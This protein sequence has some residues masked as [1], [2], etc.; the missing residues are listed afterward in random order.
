MQLQLFR[1]LPLRSTFAPVVWILCGFL[2]FAAFSVGF[3]L[4]SDYRIQ[5]NRVNIMWAALEPALRR[6]AAQPANA[7]PEPP[8]QPEEQQA[9]PAATKK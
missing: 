9:P 6:T 8:G 1:D 2:L 5:A 4:F 7:A 3:E